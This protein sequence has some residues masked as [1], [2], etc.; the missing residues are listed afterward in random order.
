MLLASFVRACQEKSEKG[1]ISEPQDLSQA[2]TIALTVTEALEQEKFA[3]TFNANLEKSVRLSTRQD[4][5]E[6]AERHSPKRVANLPRAR[7]YAREAG[8]EHQVALGTP[9]TGGTIGV[10]SAKGVGTSHGNAARGKNAKE[11]RTPSEKK[12]E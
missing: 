5:K 1:K 2:L 3:E 7:R 6:F 8:R 11:H 4:D 9:N 10:T 12:Y